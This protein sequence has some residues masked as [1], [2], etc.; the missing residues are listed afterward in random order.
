MN[1]EGLELDEGGLEFGVL[2]ERVARLVAT[3]TR[4][5]ETAERNRE[6]ALFVAV[7]P[8]RSRA[9]ASGESMHGRDEIGR[10]HV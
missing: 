10:A 8:D 6:V 9:N 4:H 7:D 2:L 3:V 1:G 5:L